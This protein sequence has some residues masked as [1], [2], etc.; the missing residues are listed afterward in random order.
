M[1]KDLVPRMMSKPAASEMVSSLLLA[2][3]K[4]QP[5][6]FPCGEMLGVQALDGTERR[7]LWVSDAGGS[8][9]GWLD[10]GGVFGR[11]S[12]VFVL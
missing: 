8:R 1:G 12:G 9:S 3:S 5:A 11:A 7:S 6:T 4:L 2:V 10:G